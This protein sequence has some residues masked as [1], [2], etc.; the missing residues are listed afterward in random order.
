MFVCVSVCVC[1]CA[2]LHVHACMCACMA[3]CSVRM[4]SCGHV[5]ERRVQLKEVAL[6][7]LMLMIHLPGENPPS[8][9]QPIKAISVCGVCVCVFRS[10]RWFA[11][12]I[13]THFYMHTH[14]YTHPCSHTRASGFSCSQEACEETNKSNQ[15]NFIEPTHT[16]ETICQHIIVTIC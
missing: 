16:I 1:V 11:I 6:T 3:G 7:K 5:Y 12:H 2:C 15:L 14:S 13:H 4:C 8:V 10:F 9:E